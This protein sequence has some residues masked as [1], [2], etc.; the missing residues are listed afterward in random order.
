[1]IVRPLAGFGAPTAIRISVGT[2]EENDILA[3][4]LGRVLAAG[5]ARRRIA[6]AARRVP[7]SPLRRQLVL[8]RRPGSF[9]LLFLATLGSGLGTW[10]ATIALTADLT[11]RTDRRGG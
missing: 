6:Y 7:S 10:L 1:M 2:P 3:A 4:V 5:L 11:A 8:L 9:R